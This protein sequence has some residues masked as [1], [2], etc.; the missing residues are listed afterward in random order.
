MVWLYGVYFHVHRQKVNQSPTL[1]V[2]HKTYANWFRSVGLVFGRFKFELN[3][4]CVYMYV[5]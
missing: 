1:F 2:L 3:N 5:C 4:N